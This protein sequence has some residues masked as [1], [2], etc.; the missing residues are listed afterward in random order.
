M[1]YLVIWIVFIVFIIE[2]KDRSGDNTWELRQN[3]TFNYFFSY[4]NNTNLKNKLESCILILKILEQTKFNQIR[5][6]N[7]L[8]FLVKARLAVLGMFLYL[9]VTYNAN[10]MY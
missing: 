6:W 9:L 1:K 10:K 2:F 4:L 3:I 5:L 7:L 8:K